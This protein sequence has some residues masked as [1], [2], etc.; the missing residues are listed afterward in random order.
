M[1]MKKYI[2]NLSFINGIMM[3]NNSVYLLLQ[4][5]RSDWLLLLD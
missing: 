4:R 1:E 3:R 5:S 2:N